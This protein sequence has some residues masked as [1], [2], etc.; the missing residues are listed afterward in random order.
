MKKIAAFSDQTTHDCKQASLPINIWDETTEWPRTGRDR[1]YQIV[2]CPTGEAIIGA[3]ILK[4]GQQ[5]KRGPPTPPASA[6]LL[7]APDFLAPSRL[8]NLISQM[9]HSLF[10]QANAWAGWRWRGSYLG[11]LRY[12]DLCF[13]IFNL[14]RFP[15]FGGLKHFPEDIIRLKQGRRNQ[16]SLELARFYLIWFE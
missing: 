9:T 11:I 4:K 7:E 1:L 3:V 2:R 8:L 10:A 15:H 16:T 14:W 12:D 13:W 5:T 6:R